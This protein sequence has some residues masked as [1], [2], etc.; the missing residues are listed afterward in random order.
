MVAIPPGCMCCGES[1]DCNRCFD[2]LA[3]RVCARA[4]ARGARRRGGRL[5]LITMEP[6]RSLVAFVGC[7]A[8]ATAARSSPNLVFFL[9]VRLQMLNRYTYC[10]QD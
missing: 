7:T 5:R 6:M 1:C 3:A 8:V 4:G 9:C 10:M 2:C